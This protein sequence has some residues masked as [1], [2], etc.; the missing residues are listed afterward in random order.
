VTPEL[1]LAHAATLL[2]ENETSH[3]IVINDAGLPIG[4]LS[5]LD[6]ARAFAG[7][8]ALDAAG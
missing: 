7:E 4:V 6:I 5:T 8:A 2:V 3:L 1:T